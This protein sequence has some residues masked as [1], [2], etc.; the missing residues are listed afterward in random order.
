MIQG[1]IFTIGL[2]VAKTCNLLY[3]ESDQIGGCKEVKVELC[4]KLLNYKSTQCSCYV[5]VTAI[6]FF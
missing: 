3:S 2:L 4:V 5:S 6:L 1:P